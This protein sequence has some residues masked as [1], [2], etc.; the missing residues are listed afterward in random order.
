MHLRGVLFPLGR[1]E[2]GEKNRTKLWTT[3]ISVVGIKLICSTPTHLKHWFFFALFYNHFIHKFLCWWA[4]IYTFI[5]SISYVCAIMCSIFI[6]KCA[7]AFSTLVHIH[8]YII[9]NYC[10][11]TTLLMNNNNNHNKKT[12][13][14]YRHMVLVVAYESRT[15]LFLFSPIFNNYNNK[16]TKSFN[17]KFRI[18]TLIHNDFFK[19]FF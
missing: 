3:L 5:W 4:Y 11:W 14:K 13:H 8:G 19:V 16:T 1:F 18:K 9:G 12:L 15:V 17:C 7:R 2:E 6:N 10:T